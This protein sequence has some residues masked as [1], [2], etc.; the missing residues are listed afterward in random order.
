M[1]RKLRIATCFMLMAVLGYFLYAPAANAQDLGLVAAAVEAEAS[2]AKPPASFP[3]ESPTL[4]PSIAPAKPATVC[5]PGVD[6]PPGVVCPGPDCNPACEGPGA[7]PCEDCPGGDCSVAAAAQRS[8]VTHRAVAHRGRVFDREAAF[9]QR[10][11]ARRVAARVFSR[12]REVVANRP[13][14]LHR[15]VGRLFGGRCH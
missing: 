3:L 2:A 9:M 7:C 1:R 6:C 5:T 12:A 15:A 10:G 4:A 11:P 13:Q 14:L 8:I